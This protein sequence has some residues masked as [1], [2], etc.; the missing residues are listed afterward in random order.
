MP[1]TDTPAPETPVPETP[2]PETPAPTPEVL[3]ETPDADPLEGNEGPEGDET[4]NYLNL[5]GAYSLTSVAKYISYVIVALTTLIVVV[6]GMVTGD[7]SNAVMIMGYFQ[8][9]SAMGQLSLKTTPSALIEFADVFSFANYL[10]RNQDALVQ[11]RRLQSNGNLIDGVI[12]FADRLN[13]EPHNLFPSVF[14]A[15]WLVLAVLFILMLIL[16][17]VSWKKVHTVPG[18]LAGLA[19]AFSL[20]SLYPISMTSSFQLREFGMGGN[21]RSILA[22]LTLV[23]NCVGILVLYCYVTHRNSESKLQESKFISL[24]GPVYDDYLYKYRTFFMIKGAIEISTGVFVGAMVVLP[25]QLICIL[26]VNLLYLGLILHFQPYFDKV[27]R[28]C[29]IAVVILRMLVFGLFSSFVF[30]E[31]VS[32]TQETIVTWTIILINVAIFVLLLFQQLHVLCLTLKEIFRRYEAGQAKQSP[33][34]S[35]ALV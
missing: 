7:V 6:N 33:G 29:M 23:L 21:W 32:E 24:W 31:S 1:Q 19:V 16:R 18:K 25:S 30:H 5:R 3:P 13:I 26:S 11:S 9:L 27:R 28:N 4:T 12:Q 17:C 14:I 22:V 2:V 15:Y 20:L 8:M 34:L 35:D 10:T